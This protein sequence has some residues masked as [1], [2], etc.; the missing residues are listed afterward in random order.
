MSTLS[1]LVR[2]RSVDL[3]A[4]TAFNTFKNTL[5]LGDEIVGLLRDDLFAIEGIDESAAETWVAACQA[6]QHW[7]NP[8]KHRYAAFLATD[9][10]VACV[11][12]D[13]S[14]P[15]PWLQSMVS[16]D[17]PDLESADVEDPRR[18]WIGVRPTTGAYAVP[19]VAWDREEGAGSLPGGDWP[20][21][22]LARIRGVVWTLVL[23]ADRPEEASARAE[24]LV[25]TRARRQGLL[26]H[27]HMEGWTAWGAPLAELDPVS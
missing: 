10:A 7:F 6:Q 12:D 18:A 11:R 16:S 26:V 2:G 24:G 13:G 19:V 20:D 23:R 25:S 14:W 3:V 5:G 1:F 15:E 21:G 4:M 22:S 8:N 9:G 27:P 17:R